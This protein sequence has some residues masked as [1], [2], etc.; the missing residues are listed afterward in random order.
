MLRSEKAA[1]AQAR[2]ISAQLGSS[3]FIDTDFGPKNDNDIEGS[4]TSIYKTG[5]EPEGGYV[6]PDKMQ[7]LS[8]DEICPRDKIP[9]FVDDGAGSNDVK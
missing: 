4:S 5:K 8:A 9:Q 3:K 7:W 1:L 6:A 2:A